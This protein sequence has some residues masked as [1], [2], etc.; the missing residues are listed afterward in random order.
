MCCKGKIGGF[1]TSLSTLLIQMGAAESCSSLVLAA[2]LENPP[3]APRVLLG[4]SNSLRPA[5]GASPYCYQA[6]VRLC[7][8]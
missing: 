7:P 4:A 5:P 8:S 6:G 2:E 1:L 3:L